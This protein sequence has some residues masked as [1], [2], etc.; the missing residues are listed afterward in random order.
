MKGVTTLLLGLLALA[1][2]AACDDWKYRRCACANSESVGYVLFATWTNPIRSYSWY[3]FR[4]TAR[5]NEPDTLFSKRCAV[6]S[7][8]VDCI[9]IPDAAKYPTIYDE[10][11][12]WNVYQFCETFEDGVETCAL[13]DHL[14]VGQKARKWET[15]GVE[16]LMDCEFE[17]KTLWAPKNDTTAFDLCSHSTRAGDRISTRMKEKKN[18]KI[19]VRGGEWMDCHDFEKRNW[20]F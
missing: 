11:N 3:K 17:C 4:R 7:S 8:T 14:V 1:I 10:A 16:L 20:H 18:G 5:R 9:D 2:P 12:P 13:V 15:G 6:G 19:R